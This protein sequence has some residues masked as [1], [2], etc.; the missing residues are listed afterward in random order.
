MLRN[1]SL[2]KEAQAGVWPLEPASRRSTRGDSDSTEAAGS[3]YSHIHLP[4]AYSTTFS[5]RT[6]VH[7]GRQWKWEDAIRAGA[8]AFLCLGFLFSGLG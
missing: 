7:Q 6:L 2:G 3:L 8:E 1:S 5:S 4:L